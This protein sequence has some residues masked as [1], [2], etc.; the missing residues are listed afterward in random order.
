MGRYDT[1]AITVGHCLQLHI[2]AFSEHIK[3][4]STH[5]QGSIKWDSGA[6][7][8]VRLLKENNLFYAELQYQ[9]TDRGEKH[10]IKY[11]VLIVAVPSNLGKGLIYY[12]VCPFSHKRC[13]VLYM[14]YGSYYFKSR[15][16]YQHRIYYSS[17]LSSRLDKHND[18]YWRLEK[19]LNSLYKKHKKEH[20]QGKK[21]KAWQRI[22]R[23]ERKLEYHD[24][25]RWRVL[26]KA[27]IKS[28]AARGVT[29]ARELF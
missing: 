14:G 11:K 23:L 13:K 8:G 21:T 12:F 22:E 18:T 17:Q 28:M 26:P 5:L 20:Y 15:E 27:L 10:D 24:C 9:K 7:I 3:K 2:T 6:N 4:G 25:M 29:D 19:Q 16:A 1:G